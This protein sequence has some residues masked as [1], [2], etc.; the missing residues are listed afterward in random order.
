MELTLQ[1]IKNIITISFLLIC[2]FSMAQMISDTLIL[3][4]VEINSRRIG[5]ASGFKEFEIDNT[6][7]SDRASGNLAELLSVVAP[8]FVKSYVPGGLATTSIRGASASHT[9]VLWNGMNINSPMNGQTDFSQIPLFFVDKASLFFG[10]GS[11]ATASGSLGGNVILQTET[12]WNNRFCVKLLQEIGSFDTYKTGVVIHTGRS[13]FQSSTRF[14]SVTSENDFPY[15]NNSISGENPPQENRISAAYEQ[16]GFLQELNWKATDRTTASA[17]VWV[18][19]NHRNI[20]PN[21]M[22]MAPENNE[23]YTEL[24]TRA[25]VNLDQRFNQSA[26]SFQSGLLHSNSNYINLLAG[27]DSDNEVISSVN[28]LN[29]SFPKIKKLQLK[30]GAGYDYHH[31]DA[32]NYEDVKTRKEAHLKIS[33]RYS[34]EKRLTMNFLLRQELIDQTFSPLVP[35][36]AALYRI[37][38]QSPFS[39]SASIARNF[40]M[41]SLNDLYWIPGGNQNLVNET[42]ITGDVGI[43]VQKDFSTFSLT[44]A[45]NGFYLDINDWIAWQPD[46]VFSY[47]RPSNFKNV[48]SKGIEVDLDVSGKIGLL[49]LNFLMN[50]SFTSTKNQKPQS[51]SDQS[52]GKQ[53]IYVPV[54]TANQSLR[55]TFK[56]FSAGYFLNYVGTRNT[57]A[58][59][60]RYLPGYVLQDITLSKTFNLGKSSFS[61]RFAVNNFANKQYQTIAWQPMP[62]RNFSFSIQYRFEK[63]NDEND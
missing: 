13:R 19:D 37:T 60:S 14:S 34:D 33:A 30:V 24:V 27:I 6:L 62:G 32:E 50:Y 11:A 28:Q 20:P 29:Y 7:I 44:G 42:G 21:M 25:V 38:A 12:D 22:V 40:R 55:L 16:K 4:T 2:Q 63:V 46:S 15:R 51:T 57:T 47:W 3:E 5:L 35:S 45:I 23:N 49:T 56:E 10:P 53:L 61:G 58:D 8:V 1:T 17:K 48:I 41:P 52:V 36:I 39:V 54:H 31:V 26:F 59:N 43:K 18:Q 9:Q